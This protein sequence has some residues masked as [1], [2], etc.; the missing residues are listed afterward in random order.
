MCLFVVTFAATLAGCGRSNPS[1]TI[2]GENS[3]VIMASEIDMELNAAVKKA[4]AT[5]NTFVA[6]TSTSSPS[7]TNA[8][9]KVAFDYGGGAE[10]IWAND[11]VHDNGTFTGTIDEDALYAPNIRAGQ[12]V[13]VT[14]DR[15]S[16]WLVVEDGKLHGGYTIKVLIKSLPP[17]QQRA[18]MAAYGVTI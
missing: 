7:V 2:S 13:S 11:V 16:D 9:I 18:I 14:A 12:Q 17:E 4:Q 6:K 8:S 3:N 5:L 15:I 10:H 1:R